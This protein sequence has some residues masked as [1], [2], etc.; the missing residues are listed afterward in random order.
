MATAVDVRPQFEPTDEQIFSSEELLDSSQIDISGNSSADNLQSVSEIIEPSGQPEQPRKKKN[1]YGKEKRKESP[2]KT[3]DTPRIKLNPRQKQA[4]KKKVIDAQ[5][6]P[7]LATV[8]AGLGAVFGPIGA[9]IGGALGAGLGLLA[10]L[11]E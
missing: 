10:W 1:N 6:I 11:L 7:G 5:I 9:V 3:K 2:K 8:G 4:V